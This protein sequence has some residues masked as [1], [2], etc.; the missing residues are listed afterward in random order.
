MSP[1]HNDLEQNLH[2]MFGYQADAMMPSTPAW[3]DTPTT[4]LIDLDTQRTRRRWVASS[5]AAIATVAAIAVAVVGL[6]GRNAHVTT[7]LPVRSNPAGAPISW[8]TPQV[9]L[10][11]D[12]FVITTNGQTFNAQNARVNLNSDPGDLVLH[13]AA[14]NSSLEIYGMHLATNP[15]RYNC[16]KAAGDYIVVPGYPGVFD[17]SPGTTGLMNQVTVLD[18]KTCAAP[19]NQSAFKL[20]WSSSNPKV[21]TVVESQCMQ[22]NAACKSGELIDVKGV[23]KGKATIHVVIRDSVTGTVVGQQDFAAHVSGNGGPAT[24]PGRQP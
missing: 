22:V 14:S 21:M 24:A 4:N 9:D 3:D 23:H 8:K 12:N 5:T 20:T 2:D 15:S 11:A 17:G 10:E 13:D 18:A 16:K 19:A 7:K 6:G 1:T